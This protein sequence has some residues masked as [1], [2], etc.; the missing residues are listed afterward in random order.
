M[1]SH[2]LAAASSALLRPG[3]P[4]AGPRESS[5]APTPRSVERKR[6]V[7]GW[8]ERQGSVAET[9]IV[10]GDTV[11]S[12][13]GKMSLD[14]FPLV[15]I[16]TTTIT[17]IHHFRSGESRTVGVCFS[18]SVDRKLF[19]LSLFG[20]TSRQRSPARGPGSRP[21]WTDSKNHGALAGR[22]TR[23]KSLPQSALLK[24]GENPPTPQQE[25]GRR[26][27]RGGLGG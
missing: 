11:S 18:S 12:L 4:A 13:A 9:C 24:S 1:S 19:I 3:P 20:K 7:R 21:G 8:G 6:S 23:G 26:T 22:L 15:V 14:L 17:E 5:P 27:A 25:R 16:S 10:L 2:P